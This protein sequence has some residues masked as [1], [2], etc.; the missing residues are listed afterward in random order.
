MLT[1]L[2]KALFT[3]STGLE[4]TN[5]DVTDQKAIIHLT[6]TH[7]SVHCPSCHTVS[8]SLHSRYKRQV[9]DLPWSGIPVL[10]RLAV[11]RFRD[12]EPTCTY[13]VFTERLPDVLHPFARRTNRFRKTLEHVALTAGGE[14]GHRLLKPLG[15]PSVQTRC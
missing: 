8:S 5:L 10:L 12:P 9:T 14:L 4:L 1:I 2:F 3:A 7:P 13:Q 6:S 11:R 15:C